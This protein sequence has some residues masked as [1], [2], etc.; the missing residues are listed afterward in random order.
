[1]RVAILANSNI[2]LA[3]EVGREVAAWLTAEG[4]EAAVF[5]TNSADLEQEKLDDFA[6]MIVLGGDGTTLRAARV[7]APYNLPIFGINLGRVGF[8]SEAE[9]E[10]WRGR[11][12]RVLN[13]EH[14]VETRLMLRAEVMRDGQ[15]QGTLVGLNEMVVG[16]GVH[17]RM[18]TFHLSVDDDPVT[19]YNADALIAATPTG[20]PAYSLAAGGPIL[21]PQ[22]KNFL[23]L[24]VA[25]HLSFQQALVLH[26]KAVIMVRLET[27]HEAVVTADGQDEIA[28]ERGDEVVICRYGHDS[29]FIRLDSPGYFYQRL[30]EKL[31]YWSLKTVQ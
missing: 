22:L 29:R 23:V 4:V 28:V 18:A 5:P 8:L 15:S 24:P 6:F 11:I 21:P 12:G 10:N 16:R 3:D 31:N 25:P 20:S 9:P 17:L 1:M 26:E 27:G 7:A 30:M 19:V 13:N 14:W 2:G